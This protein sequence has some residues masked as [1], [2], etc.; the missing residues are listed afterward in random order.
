[1]EDTKITAKL[2]HLDIEIRRRELVDEHAEE[3]TIRMQATPNFDAVGASI[4]P[5]MSALA[6][7][8]PTLVWMNVIQQTWQPWLQLMALPSA[9]E[10]Q[11]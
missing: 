10:S 9:A 8:N 5:V 6:S 2:P 4:L 7:V 3:L 1:M 11:D